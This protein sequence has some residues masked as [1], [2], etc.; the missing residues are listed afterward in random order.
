MSNKLFDRFSNKR[1]LYKTVFNTPEGKDLLK[2]LCMFCNYNRPTYVSGD[3][4]ASAYNEGMR[5][6]FLRIQQFVNLDEND[7]QKIINQSQGE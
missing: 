3:P 2:D 1:R 6:V 7:L 4:Y 5:R